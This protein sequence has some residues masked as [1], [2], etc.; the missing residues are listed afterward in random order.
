[1][2]LWHGAD[3]SFC[4]MLFCNTF[5]VWLLLLSWESIWTRWFPFFYT[6]I[7]YECIYGSFIIQRHII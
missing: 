4:F 2:K 3:W 6:I 1:M 7:N 5:E